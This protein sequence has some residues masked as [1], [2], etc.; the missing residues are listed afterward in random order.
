MI[1]DGGSSFLDDLAGLNQGENFLPRPIVNQI[2]IGGFNTEEIDNSRT[3]LRQ[4]LLD[5]VGRIDCIGYILK[6]LL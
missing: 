3:G 5:V 6:S 4:D 2:D 1:A